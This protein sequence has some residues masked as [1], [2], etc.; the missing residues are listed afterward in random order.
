MTPS[1]RASPSVKRFFFTSDPGWMTRDGSLVISKSS[2]PRVTPRLLCPF[3]SEISRMLFSEKGIVIPNSPTDTDGAPENLTD[4]PGKFTERFFSCHAPSAAGL[5]DE[6]PV[7]VAVPAFPIPSVSAPGG[8]LKIRASAARSK[9]ADIEGNG[10]THN[11]RI[12]DL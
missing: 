5:S 4:E 7:H 3:P 6:N 11:I 9:S 8:V 2:P 1:D 12:K 10:K